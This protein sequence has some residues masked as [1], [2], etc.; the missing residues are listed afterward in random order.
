MKKVKNNNQSKKCKDKSLYEQ[1]NESNSPF[2][3]LWKEIDEDL[4]SREIDAQMKDYLVLMYV[5]WA[6][7]GAMIERPYNTSDTIANEIVTRLLDEYER[8]KEA[9]S[10]LKAS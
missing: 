10:L 4:Q 1:M 7:L 8:D 9:L 3:V 6:V 2:C 5:A